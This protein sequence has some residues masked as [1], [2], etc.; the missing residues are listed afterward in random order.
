MEISKVFIQQVLAEGGRNINDASV[1]AI[2]KHIQFKYSHTGRLENA[3]TAVVSGTTLTITHPIYKRFLDSRSTLRDGS[4][5][6]R[7]YPIH[8]KP[9]FGHYNE[10]AYKLMYGFTK[11][12]AREIQEKLK[13]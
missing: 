10:I 7:A 4:R 8:N 9:V 12:V 6:K 1:R 2:R 13:E 5:R 11:D 3:N